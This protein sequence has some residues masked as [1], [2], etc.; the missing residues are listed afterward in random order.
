MVNLV[1]NFTKTFGRAPSEKEI[2]DLMRLKAEQESA[3]I[4]KY[5]NERY[6]ALNKEVAKR[7]MPARPKP[8]PKPEPK[9]SVAAPM[10]G[11]KL[12]VMINRMLR[13]GLSKDK[14]AYCLFVTENEVEA[15]MKAYGLPRTNFYLKPK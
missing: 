1:D 9:P 10:Y 11:D 3:E 13:Y 15:T 7:Q 2:G 14:V 8:E 4:L 12:A 5:K 6:K